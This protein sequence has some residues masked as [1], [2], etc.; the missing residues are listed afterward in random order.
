MSETSQALDQPAVPRIKP[1]LKLWWRRTAETVAVILFAMLFLNYVLQ[2]F[3]RYVMN[4]PLVWTL[5]AAGILFISVSLWTAAFCMDF[6][7]HVN[8]DLLYKALGPWGKRILLSLTLGTFLVLAFWSLPDTVLLLEY[9][10]DERTY[11]LDMPMG[12][13]FIL[14]IVFL[15]AYAVKSLYAV[16]RAYRGDWRQFVK[17]YYGHEH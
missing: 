13:L 10:Y 2:V 14:F 5:E 6:R 16:Y 11:A 9:M 17:E 1:D 4:D 3:M 12:H 15:L 8:F 7:D